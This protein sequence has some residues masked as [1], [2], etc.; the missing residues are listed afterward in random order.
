MQ[1]QAKF[2]FQGV[3]V[4]IFVFKLCFMYGCANIQNFNKKCNAFY[5]QKIK[6]WNF[7]FGLFN[8][9]SVMAILM[10]LLYLLEHVMDVTAV[11]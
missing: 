10:M 1:V 4:S 8:E 6:F 5:Y 9:Y 2:G 7:I 3:A 11:Y